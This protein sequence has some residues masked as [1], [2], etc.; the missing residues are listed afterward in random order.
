ME[1]GQGRDATGEVEKE[2]EFRKPVSLPWRP[3]SSAKLLLSLGLSSCLD[4]AGWVYHSLEN[5]SRVKNA[6]VLSNL[7]QMCSA[8]LLSGALQKITEVLPALG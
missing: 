1:W 7:S 4:L 8:T 3:P 5:D 6:N 2:R